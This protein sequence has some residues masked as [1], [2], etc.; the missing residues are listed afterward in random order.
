M[1]YVFTRLSSKL[2]TNTVRNMLI[3]LRRADNGN[4]A[5]YEMEASH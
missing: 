5:R 1:E 3:A 2:Y 4:E